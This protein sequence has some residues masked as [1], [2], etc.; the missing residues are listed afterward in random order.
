LVSIFA[1]ITDLRQH[2]E[3]AQIRRDDYCPDQ[4]PHCGKT[5]LWR[6]GEYYRKPDRDSG[7]LN[8]VAIPRYRC[9]H[10]RR[11]CS[12]LPECLP[13]RRW[14]SWPLQHALV[15][16]L[17]LGLSFKAVSKASSASRSTLRRWWTRLKSRHRV[18][19]DALLDRY[20]EWGRTAGFKAFWQR[21]LDH[22]PLSEAMLCLHRE[23]GIIP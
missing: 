8:P 3:H 13:P 4:C 16:L 18:H 21:V 12:T 14:Y 5:G 17:L 9:P 7:E 2:I 20:P 19:R 22:L 11:T 6:H 10:C 15:R 1:G 23:G